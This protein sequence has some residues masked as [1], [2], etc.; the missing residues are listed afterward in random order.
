MQMTI[1]TSFGFSSEQCQL[2]I[3]TLCD[4]NFN[5]KVRML[6]HI[7][8]ESELDEMR[9]NIAE[10]EHLIKTLRAGIRQKKTIPKFQIINGG[11]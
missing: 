10:R 7:M 4:A 9:Q 2:L 6:E 1:T 3:D 11:K 5:D 8:Y